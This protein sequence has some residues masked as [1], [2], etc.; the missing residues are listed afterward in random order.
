MALLQ[1]YQKAMQREHGWE[2]ELTCPDCGCTTRPLYEDWDSKS[3]INFG[4]TPTIFACVACAECGRALRSV[5]GERLVAMFSDIA[6]PRANKRLIA[7]FVVVAVLAVLLPLAAQFVLRPSFN[8]TW[9]GPVLAGPMILVFN[10]R[11]ASI[12]RRCPCGT[13]KYLFM[14][15]LG[16][17]GCYRCSSC[18]RLLRLR[19]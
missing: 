16:R 4:N 9:I 5:A 17:S 13:P 12:T 3:A 15:L 14:G 10:Y 18:G 2:V 1:N 8:V 6:V 7:W 11:M 19:S